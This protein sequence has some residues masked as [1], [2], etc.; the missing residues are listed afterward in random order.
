LRRRL[1]VSGFLRKLTLV[2]ESVQGL[3]RLSGLP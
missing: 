3:P 2:P 1:G